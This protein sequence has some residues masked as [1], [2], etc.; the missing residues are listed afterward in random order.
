MA[1]TNQQRIAR[2][3]RELN[4]PEGKEAARKQSLDMADIE[5]QMALA[6]NLGYAGDIDPAVARYHALGGTPDPVSVKGAYRG[7]LEEGETPTKK[8]YSWEGEKIPIDYDTVNVMGADAAKPEI[9]AHEYRHRMQPTLSEKGN[10]LGDAATAQNSRQWDSAVKLWVDQLRRGGDNPSREEAEEN[11]L[12]R[13]SG[14][15]FGS[16]ARHRYTEQFD[17]GARP[18]TAPFWPPWRPDKANFESN[19]SREKYVKEQKN[20]AYWLRRKEQLENE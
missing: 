13:L 5:F 18:S 11:L 3:L 12:D 8:G 7:P 1:E 16:S 17:R 6:P 4:T 15:S 2:E 10:R 9:W 19:L 14:S 20:R